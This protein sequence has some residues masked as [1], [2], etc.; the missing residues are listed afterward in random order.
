MYL[1]FVEINFLLFSWPFDVKF[2]CPHGAGMHA[3][4]QESEYCTV[5]CYSD[6]QHKE[7]VIFI[8]LSLSM[9]RNHCVSGTRGNSSAKA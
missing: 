3:V 2:Q 5:P 4:I 1:H 7:L 6:D 9:P 8:M